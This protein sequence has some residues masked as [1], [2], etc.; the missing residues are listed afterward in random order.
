MVPEDEKKVTELSMNA[1]IDQ[2]MV[3][4]LFLKHGEEL[5]KEGKVSQK[6]VDDACRRVLE[7]KYE[8]GLF[9]DPYRY[10]N[11]ERKAAQTMSADKIALSKEACA[12][13]T[14]L[15]KNAN[16]V[17]P[18]SAESKIAFIGPFIKDQ[19]SLIGN[20]SGAG[21]WQ[22]SVSIWDALG[23]KFGADKF[24]YAKG[25]NIIDD[26]ALVERLN[27][28]GALLSKDD[29]TP[30]Q[31]I[32][33]AVE[34]AKQADKVVVA[35]GE[36]FCM[37]GEAACRSMIGLFDNQ[38]ALLKALK[39]TGKPIV[40]VLM[41]GRPLTLPWEDANL[42]GIVETW[43]GGTMAGPAITEVLF[44][45]V[46]PTARLSMSFPV[47][48]GQIP[49]YYN[50]KTTGRPWDDKE[51][52]RSKYLDVSN[53]PLYP[54]GYGLSYTKYSYGDLVVTP[55]STTDKITVNIP[56]TN[57]GKRAGVETVQLYVR[58][59]VG[60][61]TRPEKELKGFQRVEIK[62]GETANVKFELTRD[63]LRFY[64]SDLKF[65]AEPGEFKVFVG[66]NSRDVKEASFTLEK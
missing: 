26:A 37:S 7:A 9:E 44:G 51:K 54:F 56:V 58:D 47:N 41:N 64:N 8:L 21:E 5:V 59:M 13:S 65:D 35:L 31:L 10:M 27:R 63:D 12:K 11:E 50:A 4:E 28:D 39:Q 14:V 66:P 57:T 49:I 46:N 34:T 24:L 43:Y 29:K 45:D 17:L 40:L 16:D 62:P 25:C 33:E 60:S 30:Q 48:V 23:T 20:W 55:K 61:I 18:L 2:D 15:L 1:G 22:K 19:R 36:P 38:V 52:Y 3:G 53:L 6:I 42:D 32:D